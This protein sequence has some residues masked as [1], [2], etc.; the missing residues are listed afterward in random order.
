MPLSACKPG[1]WYLVVNCHHC[2]TRSLLP[3]LSDGKSTIDAVYTWRCPVCEHVD[4]REGKEVER[5]Q[6][7]LRDSAES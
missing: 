4:Q 2:G 1:E 3:D 6:H 5:Y 7:P